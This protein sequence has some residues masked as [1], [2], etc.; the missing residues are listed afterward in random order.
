MTLETGGPG[1]RFKPRP[2]E[3]TRVPAGTEPEQLLM[4]GQQR[5]TSLYQ[6][7]RSDQPVNTMDAR[8][9]KLLR[10]Y[11]IDIAKAI[12]ADGN[13]EDAI[14]AVP[15]DHRLRDDFGR[16]VTLALAIHGGL[17]LVG[18]PTVESAPDL[19]R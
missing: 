12:E 15:A 5:L 3:G 2:L 4:D 13:R 17:R 6:A 10:W 11:Y 9:K 19:G 1:T 8:G 14:L 18:V 16:R 7:L